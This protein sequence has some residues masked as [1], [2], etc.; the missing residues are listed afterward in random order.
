GRTLAEYDQGAFG[1]FQHFERTFDRIGTGDLRGRRINDLH[2]RLFSGLCRHHLTEQFGRQI[3]VDAART[4]GNSSA[5]R[6]RKPDANILRVQYA[7]GRLAQW[8]G[9]R[10][11]VHFLVVALLQVDDLTLGRTRDEDHRKA[12]GRR[13]GERGQSVEEAGG[14]HRE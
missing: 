7:E 5:D 12:V 2:E 6:S 1:A 13:V 11:L 14:R 9:D 4:T 8:L 10:Q 3:K